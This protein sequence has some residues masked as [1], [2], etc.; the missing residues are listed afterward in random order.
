VLDRV[1][2]TEGEPPQPV[3]LTHPA[4]WGPTLLK[5]FEEVHRLA[6]RP[7]IRTITEPAASASHYVASRPLREGTSLRCTT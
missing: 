1:T 4:N 6:G 3:V 2:R 5:S 7:G